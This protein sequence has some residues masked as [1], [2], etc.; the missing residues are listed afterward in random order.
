MFIRSVFASW[1]ATPWTLPLWQSRF[2][3]VNCFVLRRFLASVRKRFRKNLPLRTQSSR[4]ATL[5]PIRICR[6]ALG[7]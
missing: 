4:N 3:L 7:A 2:F 1:L 5:S 6:L